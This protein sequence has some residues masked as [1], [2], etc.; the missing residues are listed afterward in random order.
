MEGKKFREMV[1]GLVTETVPGKDE[2]VTRIGNF[3]KF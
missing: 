3:D 1:G 2:P